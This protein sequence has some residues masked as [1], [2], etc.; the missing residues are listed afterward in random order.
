MPANPVKG[1]ISFG[2]LAV[3]T[4]T[5]NIN[6]EG[7][8]DLEPNTVYKYVVFRNGAIGNWNID[9][10]NIKVRGTAD[11]WVIGPWVVPGEFSDA[12]GVDKGHPLF[13]DPNGKY[14]VK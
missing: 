5:G 6:V 2:A 10:P 1:K 3:I 7:I 8:G 12:P 9:V 13:V 4:T 11:I 14:I